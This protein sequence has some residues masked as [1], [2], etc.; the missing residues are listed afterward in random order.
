[1]IV[2]K[3]ERGSIYETVFFVLR[4]NA[5]PAIRTKEDMLI[6]ANKIISNNRSNQK[7]KGALAWHYIKKRTPAFLAGAALGAIIALAHSLG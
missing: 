4:A 5:T 1:M 7:R 2:V 6:E 3:G